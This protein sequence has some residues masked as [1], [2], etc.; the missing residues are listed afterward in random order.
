MSDQKHVTSLEEIMAQ[1]AP[2]IITIPGFR[3][4]TTI[5]VAIRPID[6]KTTLLTAGIGN[7]FL[8]SAIGKAQAK[9][10]EGKDLIKIAEELKD[11]LP[12]DEL[13]DSEKLTPIV[14]AV[15]REALV[16]PTYE[17]FLEVAPLK[18]EQKW[19]IYCHALG[20]TE[21]IGFFR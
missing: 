18:F 10:Q 6:L 19:E 8:E 15:C 3:P 20:S 11:E 1:A 17:Q 13:N 9:A 12:E 7:P 5:N 2:D 14:D 21:L 4:G 16:E